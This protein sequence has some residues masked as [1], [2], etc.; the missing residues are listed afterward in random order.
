M[1][2]IYALVLFGLLM[3]T[4][5]WPTT[6]SNADTKSQL[7]EALADLRA[8]DEEWH[9]N[10]A[11]FRTLRRKK[12]LPENDVVVAEF[13][14]F[15]AALRRK[16]LEN[17]HVFRTLGG[18]PDSLGF[19]CGLPEEEPPSGKELPENPMVV[20]TDKE[21]TA[22]L[23][24]PLSKS[25]SEFDK[26]LQEKEDELRGQLASQSSGGYPPNANVQGDGGKIRSDPGGKGIHPGGSPSS[27]SGMRTEPR[28]AEAGAGPGV[29]KRVKTGPQGKV[30]SGG[31]DDDVVARQLREA[32]EKEQDP[33][34]K[35]KLWAEYRKYKASKK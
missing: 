30:V 21:K 8:S 7:D 23:E 6:P 14:E 18:D 4:M 32:A 19:D 11:E 5:A 29:K 10:D 22:S 35:E 20:Q 28:L 17:C 15:V 25:L 34:M 27:S 24:A 31:S 33:L 1:S 12:T 9:Q 3:G 26:M 13:A 16:M 2:H